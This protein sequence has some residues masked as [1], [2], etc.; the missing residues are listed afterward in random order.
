MSNIT[1]EQFYSIWERF[2]HSP[3]ATELPD[4]IEAF[5]ERAEISVDYFIAEFL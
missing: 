5:C 3:I 4:D 2:A 1:E